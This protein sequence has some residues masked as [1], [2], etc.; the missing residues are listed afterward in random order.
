MHNTKLKTNPPDGP[1]LNINY[2][3]ITK[4][5]GLVLVLT[6]QCDPNLTPKISSTW[7]FSRGIQNMSK[8]RLDIRDWLLRDFLPFPQLS[9]NGSTR[10]ITAQVKWI[11]NKIILCNKTIHVTSQMCNAVLVPRSLQM[12]FVWH[13]V[14]TLHSTPKH[15]FGQKHECPMQS[16]HKKSSYTMYT[17]MEIK[18]FIHNCALRV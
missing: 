17:C 15:S 6:T 10:K 9:C 16:N 18:H 7:A 8:G 11:Y 4:H 12:H 5:Q 13:F 14:G 3:S 2:K 1:T